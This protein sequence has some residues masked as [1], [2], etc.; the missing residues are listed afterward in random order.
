MKIEELAKYIDHTLLKPEARAENI[1]Q[2]CWEATHWGFYAVCV[3]P[4]WVELASQQLE[5]TA[6]KVASVV[7]FP[8]GA[9]T[10]Y[11]KAR[12]AEQAVSDGAQEIDMVMNL[13]WAMDG[14]WKRVEEDITEV[15]QHAQPALVKVILETGL[16]TREQIVSACKVAQQ[17]GAHFVKTSTGFNSGGAEVEVVRLMVQ[18]VGSS[19]LVKA[20]GGIRDVETALKMIEAGASRLGM[21]SAVQ[22][23]Q[24]IG[25]QDGY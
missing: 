4:C 11:I 1:I 25:S 13:G 6:V 20:S 12:E 2:L 16:L 23:M 19:M 8:H 18:T 21:S 22:M 7:G 24:G 15:V 5:G 3:Q 14:Q 10:T 17:A 9:N